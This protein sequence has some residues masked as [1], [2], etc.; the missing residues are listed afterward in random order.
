MKQLVEKLKPL[1][2]EISGLEGKFRLFA[3]VL[4][5]GA[6][7]RWDLVVSAPYLPADKKE[8]FERLAKHVKSRLAP[9]ELLALS[10]IVVLD[11]GN[12]TLEAMNKA[13]RVEHGMA[14][15]KD[16]NFF[17]LQVEHAYIITSRKAEANRNAP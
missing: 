14:E 7:D 17:G 15:V 5:E 6:Q 3:L 13:I 12:P 1:E 8:S 11:E 2:E 4:R 10:R 9:Q 16:R